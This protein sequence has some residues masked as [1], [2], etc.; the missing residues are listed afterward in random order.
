MMRILRT[1]TSQKMPNLSKKKMK[2][3]VKLKITSRIKIINELK[4]TKQ[5]SSILKSRIKLNIK[6]RLKF[7]QSS[8]LSLL[9]CLIIGSIVDENAGQPNC[10]QATVAMQDLNTHS[11]FSLFEILI[12]GLI[13]DADAGQPNCGQATVAM[14]KLNMHLSQV[15]CIHVDGV[16]FFISSFYHS[17]SLNLRDCS[18]VLL[19]L[20]REITLMMMIRVWLW[21]SMAWDSLV[22]GG[23][24]MLQNFSSLLVTQNNGLIA[25]IMSGWQLR[26]NIRKVYWGRR[27]QIRICNG[28][29]EKMCQQLT[30]SKA[31]NAT[32][33][34]SKAEI[35]NLYVEP[36]V[37]IAKA[38]I[39][40][41]NCFNAQSNI[42]ETKTYVDHQKSTT[43][44]LNFIHGE[45]MSGH[46][47][48]RPNT[49]TTV[50]HIPMQ[51]EQDPE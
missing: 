49:E 46:S 33:H 1:S 25:V 8:S 36:D 7:I 39:F 35:G 45:M 43:E 37:T 31:G 27:C 47:K 40:H 22:G 29:L 20:I 30:K 42:H 9:K 16:N 4:S 51:H 28:A 21:A 3:T 38:L 41:H 18:K 15:Q 6:L 14:Q 32:V 34:Q 17:T 26:G 2:E 23:V 48:G 24:S 19:N 11:S 50:H 5:G 10:G 13:V 12:T 44:L